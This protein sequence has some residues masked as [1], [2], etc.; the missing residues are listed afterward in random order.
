MTR[1]G[2]FTTRP[3]PGVSA[4]TSGAML[5][6]NADF[7]SDHLFYQVQ[8]SP[9]W[10]RFGV[11]LAMH[12][13]AILLLTRVVLLIPQHQ[14]LRH[15]SMNN[16]IT[17]IAPRLERTPR[18][19]PPPVM[20]PRR[21]L[22]NLQPPKMVAPPPEPKPAPEPPKAGPVIA[23]A[24]PEPVKPAPAPPKRE[25]VENVFPGATQRNVPEKRREVAADV[26]PG[27]GSASATVHKPAR[28]VQTGGFGDPMG[29]RGTSTKDRTLT[30]ASL[31]SFDLPAGPGEGN[32]TGG[33][34]GARGT[35]ASA[36]FGPGVAGPG[37]GSGP[38]RGTVAPAG[39]GDSNA[40]VASNNNP[41][42]AAAPK[43]AITPVEILFKP[44]P[45]YTEE[46]RQ[47]RLQGEV[48]LEVV[49]GATGE[50]R[51]MRVVRGL[52]H[53]LDESAQ[54]AAQQIRFRPARRDGQPY[55]S[56]ALVHITF[57][58]AN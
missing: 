16:P 12:V 7:T 26:F 42:P 56:A 21:F 52:G 25:V 11:S 58:L 4:R 38:R 54:R 23:K 41:K 47:L 18:A 31:G 3:E 28:Q 46:G 10:D 1:L 39:F 30:V 45:A 53:G 29:V 40:I 20:P 36:G 51:V 19:V 43:P 57:E 27:G 6:Q 49:F 13:V 44:K 9:R 48:L 33:S 34:R 32:G 22:A 50:V 15:I 17:L 2:L 8:Q 35:V 14:E 37:S 55:D 5:G 24:V